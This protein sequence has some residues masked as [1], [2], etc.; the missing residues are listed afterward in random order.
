[1]YKIGM[2]CLALTVYTLS[3]PARASSIFI[4]SQNTLQ[5]SCAS[6]LSGTGSLLNSYKL[7]L[8]LMADADNKLL[9][10]LVSAVKLDAPTSDC[11]DKIRFNSSGDAG[12]LVIDSLKV[13]TLP[14][15][16]YALKATARLPASP[17]YDFGID[18]LVKQAAPPGEKITYQ[19]TLALTSDS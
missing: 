2:I 8:S 3:L 17:Y 7:D 15:A 13:D 19:L 9:L 18:S 5:I 16:S 14:G 1:M 6:L 10:R 4:K 12:E 11:D